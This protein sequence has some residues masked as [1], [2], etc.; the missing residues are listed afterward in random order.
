MKNILYLIVRGVDNF[1]TAVLGTVFSS[2]SEHILLI[3]LE[4]EAFFGN[5]SLVF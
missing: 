1:V 5:L 2:S 3:I 4:E